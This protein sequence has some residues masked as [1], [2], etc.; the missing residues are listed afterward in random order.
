MTTASNL[1]SDAQFYLSAA[2]NRYPHNFAS[3]NSID[4][5][6]KQP[7]QPLS[8]MSASQRN[9]YHNQGR[10]ELGSWRST[11]GQQGAPA[12][13]YQATVANDRSSGMVSWHV[14][15]C[16]NYLSN[17]V[18]TRATALDYR[19]KLYK[20]NFNSYHSAY[21][22]G[23]EYVACVPLSMG[24]MFLNLEPGTHFEK[25]WNISMGFNENKEEDAIRAI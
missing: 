15:I 17:S 24:P 5:H 9:C 20:S 21:W 6:L 4:S 12:S 13:G 10:T 18:V 22:L 16:L 11:S 1:V 7:Q 3:T 14:I 23:S 2:S 8:S 19:S 25:S